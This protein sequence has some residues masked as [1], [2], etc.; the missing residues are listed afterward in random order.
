M[1]DCSPNVTTHQDL[2]FK[3]ANNILIK[4]SPMLDISVGILA[5]K[6]VKSIYIIAVKNEVKELLFHQE[7]GFEG[8][9]ACYYYVNSHVI[10]IPSQ[11]MWL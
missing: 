7:K 2:F 1:D 6:Q 5:L 8:L 10:L 9:K 4:L 11:K 3:H